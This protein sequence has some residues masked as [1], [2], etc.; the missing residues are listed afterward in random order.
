MEPITVVAILIAPISVI[1]SAY[2]GK[3]ASERAIG[4][5]RLSARLATRCHI[6]LV[7]NAS[8]SDRLLWN[9]G[10]GHAKPQHHAMDQVGLSSITSYPRR[11]SQT[12]APSA[13]WAMRGP[14]ARR[15]A[16]WREGA[17]RCSQETM[18]RSL[19]RI[20]MNSLRSAPKAIVLRLSSFS[21]D[22]AGPLPA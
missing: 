15:S 14:R 5:Q 11:S 4:I 12:M 20:R 22:Q 18:V 6:P 13:T 3:P 10:R 17:P 2:V 8:R 1:T 9:R 21:T 19:N 7:E 16:L